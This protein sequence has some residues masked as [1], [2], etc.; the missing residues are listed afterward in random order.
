MADQPH[1]PIEPVLPEI[2]AALKARR[3]C[4]LQAPPGAGKTTRVPLYLLETGLVNG[5]ILMLEPRRVAARAAAERMAA[6]LGEAVG[7]RVG[8]TM[9][10]AREVSKATKIEVVTEGVLTAMI[11][12]DPELPGV[13][14]VIFDE[15]H[16]RSLQADLGLA[17]TCELREALR[18]DLNLIVMS[19]TLDAAPVAALL[20]GAPIVTAKGRAFEV[21][22]RWLD[23]PPSKN[24]RFESSIADLTRKALSETE[25]GILVF[26]PGQGEINR[27]AGL[28]SDLP[29][30]VEVMPLYGSMPFEAQRRVLTPLLDIRKIVLATAIAETS[31]TIPDIR[32]VVDGGRARRARFDPG[33]GMS[34]L[35]TEPVSRAE[36]TQRSGRAGRVAEGWCYRAWIKGAEGALPAFPPAE[37]EAADLSGLALELARWGARDVAD[38]AFLTPPPEAGLAVARA[39][40]TDL[41]ALDASGG[42]TEPGRK[43]AK[44]PLHPRLARMLQMGGPGAADLAAI[45][46]AR[47]ILR[48]AETVDLSWRLEAVKDPRGF[49]A[50]RR[51]T[52]ARGE[53]AQVRSEAKRLRR[54]EGKHDFSAAQLLS[55]A[56]PDR[57]ALRRTGDA[58][59]Y[60]MSG[61]KGAYLRDDDPLAGTR[62]LVVADLDGDGREARIRLALPTS[63]AEMRAVH[64]PHW[65]DHCR[66]SRR[67]NKVEARRQL[68]LGELVLE[69]QIW[70][71]APVD[72][73]ARAAMEGVRTLGVSCLGWSK[74]SR[75]LRARIAWLHALGEASMPDVSDAALA[76]N[77][78]DWLLP[79]LGPAR[80]KADFARLDPFDALRGYLGWEGGQTLDRLAPASIKAPTG[81][82]LAINYDAVEPEIEVRLQEMFGLTTHPVVGP[83]RIPLRVTLLSPGQKPLQTTQD[84]PGFWRSSYADVRRDMRGRYPRHPWPEDPTDS[85]PT[86]RAKPR[87]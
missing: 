42:L 49:E 10:G 23:R 60:L 12:A 4:V 77:L 64:T 18:P 33:S 73:S 26:L 17:L 36:A 22:T 1:L 87:K 46:A 82:K 31:L 53:A 54:F 75:Y 43:I 15:F 8:Y 61:G 19:A 14:A 40:L 63:E 71:D 28:L 51:A 68:R 11:Q 66:W 85:D 59:R 9:R 81:T 72:E 50:R 83:D 86:R 39:L 52:V 24:A 20:G 16:E 70:R 74:A 25:G 57:I 30:A 27:V 3:L 38:L 55:L 5:R 76:E 47:D 21:E 37:I 29:K 44:M 32:V 58:P 78:E 35:I 2:A 65:H 80:S 79:A 6:S 62:L 48:G 69:D 34:R 13:S 67:E 45:L 84:L 7:A 56:Y 41:G